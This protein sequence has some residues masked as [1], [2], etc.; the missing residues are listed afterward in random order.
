V[1][2]AWAPFLDQM[3]LAGLAL[4][5]L[6]VLISRLWPQEVHPTQIAEPPEEHPAPPERDLL[7]DVLS[8]G[9]VVATVAQVLFFW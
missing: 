3:S 9:A 1:A 8:I 2:R 4:L 5:V 6:L 7:F